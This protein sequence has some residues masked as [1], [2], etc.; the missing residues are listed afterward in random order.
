MPGRRGHTPDDM[1]SFWQD[2]R[3][4]AARQVPADVSGLGVPARQGTK[5]LKSGASENW[6]APTGRFRYCFQKARFLG[7]CMLRFWTTLEGTGPICP[8]MFPNSI[9]TA[10]AEND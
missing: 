3:P 10:I 4:E 7:K 9:G 1:I 5:G 2:G 8:V 6:R